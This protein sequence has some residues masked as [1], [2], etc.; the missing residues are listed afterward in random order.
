MQS[1]QKLRERLQTEKQAVDEVDAS[2][3]SELSK[4]GEEMARVNS[5]RPPGSHSV[6]MRRLG[7]AVRQLEDRIPTEVQELQEKHDAIQRD[8]DLTVKASEAKVRT[9]DQLYKEAVAEN[10]LLYE[11]FNGELGKIVKALKG[12][13]KDDKEELMTKLR[14]QS[15]ETART[16]KENARLKRE[17]VSLRTALKG[18]AE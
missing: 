11:K 15:E 17:I 5:T 9:I 10:E 12:K 13:G 14:D 4:I 1:P 8:M 18:G 3:R 7:A 2:L 16:K 6:E